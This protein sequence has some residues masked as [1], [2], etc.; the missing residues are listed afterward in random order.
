M[1][2]LNT[3]L[4]Y[5]LRGVDFG[6]VFGRFVFNYI[7][8]ALL[9]FASLGVYFDRLALAPLICLFWWL[10]VSDLLL[11]IC[12]CSLM[13]VCY[14]GVVCNVCFRLF[15]L[16]LFVCVLS[17]FACCL[18]G[19]FTPYVWLICCSLLCLLFVLGI[20]YVFEYSS[21]CWVCFLIICFTGM[22][23]IRVAGLILCYCL[24]DIVV[25]ISCLFVLF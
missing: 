2:V 20:L 12:C 15:I 6:L 19:W 9:W 1:F 4:P 16:L 10:V 25:A 11:L 21:F 18:P 3:R 5:L 14:L 7:C 17:L 24:G 22:F 23:L 8:F 13:G